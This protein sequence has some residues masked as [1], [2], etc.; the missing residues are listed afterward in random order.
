MAGR[1]FPDGFSW[2]TA[3]AAHQVE[4]GNWNNDWWAWEHNPEAQCEEPSGDACDQYHLYPNDIALLAQLGFDNYRFSVE[5]S[6][7]EPEEGEFST[8]ALD[9]YRR[10]CATCLEHGVDPVVTYHH[11]T[12]PRWLADRSGWELPE[13]VDRFARFCERTSAHI[14]DLV[15]RSCTINEPNIVAFIGYRLGFFPPGVV[16][17]D[18]FRTVREHFIESHRKA[19]DAIKSGPSEGP[20]GLTLS[21]ADFQAVGDGTPDGDAKAVENRDRARKAME[22]RYLEEV[23]GDDFIGVQTYTRERVGVEGALG[24]EPG[25]ELTQMNYEFW[26]EALEATIRRAWEVTE[27]VPVLVTENGCSGEDDARRIEYVRRA[28]GCVLDCLDDGIDV[29]GYTYWSLLDNFEWAYGYRPQ[30]GLIAV[31]RA[32]QQRQPKPSA[33]WLGQIARANALPT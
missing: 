19:Y 28:L 18:R 14:G 6:R 11:F 33:E 30:F 3:T 2:G 4:G 26:P 10:V 5:W 20:V 27:Q 24:P 22:D 29:L 7:I 21:M 9:H 12:T 1:T 31:D 17:A 13:A 23:R 32:T 15:S 8:A 16:D 25:V